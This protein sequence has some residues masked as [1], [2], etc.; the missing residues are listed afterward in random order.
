MWRIT[1]LK[2][3]FNGG[4]KPPTHWEIFVAATMLSRPEPAEW[5]VE[6][7][8]LGVTAVEFPHSVR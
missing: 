5:R 6:H 3:S 8:T 4:F 2:T 1:P 7:L